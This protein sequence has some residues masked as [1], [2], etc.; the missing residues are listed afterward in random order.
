MGDARTSGMVKRGH[1]EDILTATWSPPCSSSSFPTAPRHPGLRSSRASSSSSSR[2]ACPAHLQFS[3]PPAAHIPACPAKP[4]PMSTTVTQS[5]SGAQESA[6]H[7]PPSIVLS[8]SSPPSTLFPDSRPHFARRHTTYVPTS[9]PIRSSPLA[10][11]SLALGHDGTLTG[12]DDSH[13]SHSDEGK[14]KPSRIA[15]TPDVPSTFHSPR[16][17]SEDDGPVDPKSA[18]SPTLLPPLPAASKLHRLSRGFVKLSSLPSLP[19]RSSSVLKSEDSKRMPEESRRTLPVPEPPV[20]ALPSAKT[21]RTPSVSSTGS[22][23]RSIL[24]SPTTPVTAPPTTTVYPATPVRRP[25]TASSSKS[26]PGNINRRSSTYGARPASIYNSR[27]PELNW[28]STAAPPK[29]S[30]QS[31][32]A[33]GVVMPISAKDPK[34]TNRRS[35]IIQPT[36]PAIAHINGNDTKGKSRET[37]ALPSRSVSRASSMVSIGSVASEMSTIVPNGSLRVG[38]FGASSSSIDSTL[39]TLP[40]ATPALSLSRTSSV[41]SADEMRPVKGMQSS[42]VMELRVNDVQVEVMGKGKADARSSKLDS[43][44]NGKGNSN[45]KKTLDG[46][47]QRGRGTIKRA[48]KRVVGTVSVKA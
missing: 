45:V 24:L 1:R 48:W 13:G 34:F 40:P 15:S 37:L 23:R 39:S 35:V 16:S 42:L 36:S 41:T 44:E 8:S 38:G 3:S 18:S 30:R 9:R 22:N 28:L 7:R 21:V 31:L 27:D 46:T 33:E 6:K 19:S 43:K 11:P 47:I 2:R 5:S 10:G 12:S 25:T 14:S 4:A 32:K 20:W 29:F 26:L 17:S